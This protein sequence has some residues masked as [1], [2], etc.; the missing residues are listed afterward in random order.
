MA[1]EPFSEARHTSRIGKDLREKGWSIELLIRNLEHF[2]SMHNTLDLSTD[3][4]GPNST[5]PILFLPPSKWLIVLHQAASTRS[6][7]LA[8]SASTYIRG[9]KLLSRSEDEKPHKLIGKV[10]EAD[11]SLPDQVCVCFWHLLMQGNKQKQAA[12][13]VEKLFFSRVGTQFQGNPQSEVRHRCF[14]IYRAEIGFTVPLGGVHARDAESQA[15]G[16]SGSSE[17]NV[18]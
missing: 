17:W 12:G 18:R 10:G 8:L 3:R 15:G 13:C 9:P 5:P 7:N 2:M 1:P 11:G 4:A 14:T 16:I 6:R